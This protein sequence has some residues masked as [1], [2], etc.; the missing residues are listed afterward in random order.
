MRE[1]GEKEGLAREG[2]RFESFGDVSGGER[3]VVEGAIAVGGLREASV[4]SLPA[5]ESEEVAVEAEVAEARRG[6]AKEAAERL[7]ECVSSSIVLHVKSRQ[8]WRIC[9]S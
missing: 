7:A 3:A 8:K 5:G 9:E 4:E 6:Q 2:E 1:R